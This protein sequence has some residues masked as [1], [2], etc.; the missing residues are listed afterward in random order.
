MV[1]NEE[2][3]I[4]V[5]QLLKLLQQV[6]NDKKQASLTSTRVKEKVPLSADARAAAK[7]LIEALQ[8]RTKAVD[9]R[10][11]LEQDKA[12]LLDFGNQHVEAVV[13]VLKRCGNA[14]RA[15]EMKRTVAT[16]PS[17]TNRCTRFLSL[18]EVCFS[19]NNEHCCPRNTKY[20]KWTRKRRKKLM[21]GCSLFSLAWLA[22]V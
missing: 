16:V 3:V 19:P 11:Q 5:A 1:N 2:D 10:L 21:N 18:F 6:L 4:L 17:I 7:A 20:K 15:F 9:H 8:I 14:N 12:V 13:G 22:N